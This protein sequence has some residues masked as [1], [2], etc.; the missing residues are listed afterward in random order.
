MAEPFLIITLA[1]IIATL[2]A[3][4]YVLRY[5]VLVERRIERIEIHIERLV[6][7]MIKK[8]PKKS[9]KPVKRKQRRK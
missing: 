4:V 2:A 3:I 5:V 8:K 6:H 7:S 1:T 9:S